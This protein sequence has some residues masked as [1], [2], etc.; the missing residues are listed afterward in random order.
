MLNDFNIQ[1]VSNIMFPCLLS[2]FMTI[3]MT[4]LSPVKSR[5]EEYSEATREALLT[6]ARTLFVAGGYQQVGIEAIAKAAR[7]TRG[8]FYHHF[9]DKAA[10]FEALVVALQAD[11]AE[12]IR[13]IAGER[14]QI[15]D[16]LLAGVAAFLDIF[17]EPA[18]LRLVIEDAPSVLGL[19]RCRRIEEQFTIGLMMG[20]FADL[21]AAGEINVDDP[22][23]A[24][25]MIAAMICQA[26]LM[27]VDAADAPQMRRSALNLI[28]RMLMDLREPRQ[29]ARSD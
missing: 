6:A 2:T 3:G 21:R 24:A 16:R 9:T 23:L 15:W 27:L 28:E 22:N 12:R 1:Y 18:Y 29:G 7:V 20:A 5:R 19:A 4:T 14:A 11:A 13:A 17:A 8:A 10:L 25:R 26:A